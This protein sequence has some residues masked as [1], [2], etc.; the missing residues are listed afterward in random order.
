MA[1]PRPG[2]R[3]ELHCDAG[4]GRVRLPVWFYWEPEDR[5]PHGVEPV[6]P[7][8]ML[9]TTATWA[10]RG[11]RDDDGVPVDVIRPS[12]DPRKLTYDLEPNGTLVLLCP[13][14]RKDGKSHRPVRLR[15]ESVQYVCAT[16]HGLGVSSVSLSAISR[17]LER[18]SEVLS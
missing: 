18:R 1:D 14:A 13:R 16:L 15:P 12:T 4:H 10:P 17:I 8:W 9:A 6:G 3:I 7:R 5:L 11:P 2:Y